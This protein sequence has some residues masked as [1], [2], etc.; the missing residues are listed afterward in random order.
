MKI[1]EWNLNLRTQKGND[2]KQPV[3]A[4]ELVIPEFVGN[5]LNNIQYD[6]VVLTEFIKCYNWKEFVGSL[7]NYNV[8]INCDNEDK[9]V[10]IAV[11][12][13][14]EVIE[15]VREINGLK[16]KPAPHFLQVK[17]RYKQKEIYIIGTR[18]KVGS[19]HKED[20]EERKKQF[21]SLKKH[22]SLLSKDGL[23]VTGDFNNAYIR[24]DYKGRPQESYNYDKIKKWFKEINMK[25]IEIEGFSHAG[26]LKEDHL[27]VSNDMK[28]KGVYSEE[29]I[30][31]ENLGQEIYCNIYFKGDYFNKK[32]ITL[33]IGY[34]DHS[35]LKAEIFL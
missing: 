22:I 2:F 6:I 21:D 29:F 25:L 17:V 8:F 33:P 5:V 7:I 4:S 9:G 23:V 10:L 15:I 27:I 20:F 26:Y 34:P 35:I 19:G 24:D 13:E 11:K 28:A 14:I 30:S 1:L 32:D 31:E 18:I 12:K 16:N 3:V